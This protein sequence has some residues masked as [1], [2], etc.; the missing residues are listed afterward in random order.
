MKVETDPTSSHCGTR[1][2]VSHLTDLTYLG[3]LGRA[4]RR[5]LTA[6]KTNLIYQPKS[7]GQM[8]NLPANDYWTS[9]VTLQWMEKIMNHTFHGIFFFPLWCRC[10]EESCR[11]V[12]FWQRAGTF[13]FGKRG[14]KRHLQIAFCF[15]RNINDNRAKSLGDVTYD[16]W[17]ELCNIIKMLTVGD[18][19]V[20]EDWFTTNFG[21]LSL[22]HNPHRLSPQLSDKRGFD[23]ITILM[24][25]YRIILFATASITELTQH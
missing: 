9:N 2:S 15:C 11:S 14:D 16:K 13:I 20:S 8:P 7:G 6:P 12:W 3:F 23:M 17:G 5:N 1:E 18:I 10:E 25:F 24:D 22:K 4:K 21:W 19:Q